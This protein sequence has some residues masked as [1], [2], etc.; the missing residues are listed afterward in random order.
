MA[1]NK[2][3]KHRSLAGQ[4]AVALLVHFL[5]DLARFMGPR[6]AA[7]LGSFLARSLGPLFREQ[8]IGLNNLAA[9]FPETTPEERQRILAGVWDNLARA[10]VDYAFLQELVAEFDPDRP[11]GG[12]I[13][14]TGMEHVIA[15]RE[16]GRP[17]IVFGAHLG[18][19][20]LAAAV[21]R[22]LGVPI[23]ALYRPP[24]NPYVAREIE[25]R[26]AFVDELVVSGRGAAFQVAAALQSGKHIGVIID[27]RLSDGGVELPF[28]GRPAMSNPIVGILA[29]HFE[30]PVHGS[31]AVRLPDGRLQLDFTAA[32]P[33]PRDRKGRVDADA[34]NRLVHG[35]VEGW[36]REHP[37]QWLWIHDRWRM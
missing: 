11:V 32:L 23:T 31:R 1:K 29:R 8:R 24:S 6:R 33:L 18:N 13:Q 30:C 25:R 21:G 15:L 27:Q 37:E 10:S 3:A 19:W 4:R 17:G 28:F 35:M 12:R 9:A 16:G 36:I 20:E 2:K 34:T 22:K 26:R 7:G 14:H 5:F